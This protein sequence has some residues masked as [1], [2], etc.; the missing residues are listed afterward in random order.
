MNCVGHKRSGDL[1]NVRR[2]LSWGKDTAQDELGARCGRGAG[3]R[4]HSRWLCHLAPHTLLSGSRLCV[5]ELGSMFSPMALLHIPNIHGEIIP[6]L[7]P[8][9]FVEGST[10]SCH[11]SPVS[12]SSCSWAFRS[13]CLGDKVGS[14]EPQLPSSLFQR[15]HSWASVSGQK[16]FL[17][18]HK[19]ICSGQEGG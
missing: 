1:R 9:S 10:E 19:W 16:R 7:A 4:P 8:S 14:V 5:L 12:G 11:L 13:R 17:F 18:I 3:G 2:R 6:T 15:E